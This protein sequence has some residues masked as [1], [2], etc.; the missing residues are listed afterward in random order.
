MFQFCFEILKAIDKLELL[1]MDDAEKFNALES[2]VKETD[3]V[4]DPFFQKKKHCYE[5]GGHCHEVGGHRF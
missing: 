3:S 5:V 4:I 1:D 2:W